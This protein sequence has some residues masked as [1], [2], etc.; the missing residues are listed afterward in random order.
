MSVPVLAQTPPA[1]AARRVVATLRAAGHTAYL[2]GGCVRDTLLGKTPKDFDVATSARPDQ[3][4]TLFPK[5]LAVGKSFGVIVVV[6]GKEQ[7]EVATFRSDVG[8]AD[9]RHPESVTFSTPEEDVKRRDFTV[10]GLFLDPETMEVL[11]FVGGQADLAAGVVRAIG[12]PEER[13]E[14]DALRMLRAVRFAGSLGFTVDGPTFRAVRSRADLIRNVSAERIG[15][16]TVRM[17]K[18]SVH[19]G[20]TLDRLRA[21]GLLRRILPEVEAM[22][23]VDQPPQFHPEGDV[24]THTRLMLD[25]M[26]PPPARDARLAMA[27]LLHDVG[28][29]PTKGW[30]RMPDGEIRPTFQS[31]ADV[32]AGLAEEILRRLKCSGSFIDDVAAMVRRHMTLVSAKEMRPAKLRKFLAAPTM[33]LEFELTRLDQVHSCGIGDAWEFAKAEYE[34]IAATPEL[35]ARWVTG[36][37]LI[38]MGVP[39][40]VGM[41]RLLAEAF[42]RQLEGLAKDRAELLDW[43]RV[44]AADCRNPADRV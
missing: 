15:Q 42:D 29:P 28:K 19:A 4:E 36:D 25:D 7:T 24:Y 23:G 30:R 41:G 8:T 17:F 44:R 1:L 12:V 34:K 33:P 9:G 38:A 13:F 27:V 11:D 14:E 16:E 40:G 18:E 6:D 2:V 22:V 5:T 21:S 20:E 43:V 10:N 26:P 32:G 3:V 35:P 37:D 39:P 31:H